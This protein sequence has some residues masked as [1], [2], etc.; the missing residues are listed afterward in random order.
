MFFSVFFL[1]FGGFFLTR[2]GIT[3]KEKADL[4]ANGAT[5]FRYF[6]SVLKQ[7]QLQRTWLTLHTLQEER[8]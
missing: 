8:K 3:G 6:F 4:K 5:A 7:I 2:A 1:V